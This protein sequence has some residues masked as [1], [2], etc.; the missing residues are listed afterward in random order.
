MYEV[1]LLNS[2]NA[3]MKA[4]FAHL[5]TSGCCFLWN[6]LCVKLCAS[7]NYGTTARNS[8]ENCFSEYL[9]ATLRCVGCHECRQVLSLQGISLI[10]ERTKN[11][12]GLSQLNKVD[13]HFCN[14]FISQELVELLTHHMQRLCLGGESTCQARVCVFFSEKIP[15]ILFCF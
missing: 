3:P 12:K 13:V 11:H 4:K 10:L 5:Y 15:V 6:T 9:A 8:L 1:W 14:G 2:P 7:W